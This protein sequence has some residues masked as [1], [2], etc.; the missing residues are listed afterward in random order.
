MNPKTVTRII[1]PGMELAEAQLR[2]LGLDPERDELLYRH[3]NGREEVELHRHP[4]GRGVFGYMARRGRG[5]GETSYV[6]VA[7]FQVLSFISDWQRLGAGPA[8]KRILRAVGTAGETV[9]A[10][11][12]GPRGRPIEWKAAAVR[13]EEYVRGYR[14]IVVFRE[15]PARG[16]FIVDVFAQEPTGFFP[17]VRYEI[18]A[19][20]IAS[21]AATE[22][23]SGGYE[24]ARPT[25]LAAAVL[26]MARD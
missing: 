6:A 13:G 10:S 8:P 25:G 16:I 14:T 9:I 24:G 18:I 21:V 17:A 20:D 1:R 15:E 19:H 4:L 22:Y 12:R 23:P 5:T 11:M 2:E 26:G 3:E 7:R